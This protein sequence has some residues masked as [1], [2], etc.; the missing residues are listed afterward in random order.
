MRTMKALTF[1]RTREDWDTSTGM[2]LEDV[3]VPE[4]TSSPGDRSEVIV[5]VRYAGFCGSDRGIWW[6]KSFGDMI[7][8]SLDE[9]GRDKRIFGH[10]L[11]GEIVDVG[12]RVTEKYGYRP[13]DIVSTESHI[14]CGTCHQCRIGEY[15]VC[16]R[17]RIIG[18]SLD[19]C[20]AEYVKLP[21]KALWRTDL[22]RIRPE[23]AAVQE[24]FGNAMHACQVTDLRGKTVAILGTGTIGLFAVL[25]AKGMGARAVIGIEPDPHHREMAAQLGC[26]LVLDPGRPPADRPWLAN[27]ELEAR[28]KEATRGVGVDVA[29]EMAGF[30]SSVNNAIKITRRGGQVVLFGVK[31]GDTVLQ[32][33]HRIVMNG[34]SLHAVVGRRI[35]ETWHMTRALLETQANGIQDAIWKVILNE[36]RGTVVDIGSWDRDAFEQVIQ[37]HPKAVLRF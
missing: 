27:P 9:E 8:G 21:A 14:V 1:D 19:G 26:D 10:E 24:P 7:L 36:G 11:L 18:I 13:G 31:N 23:V 17:D 5:K 20:F 30:N 3:P 2:V 29:M 22:S 33:A 15:H 6:R 34:L 35:F 37:A 12:A 25:I 4:L 32:D 16:A 28:V